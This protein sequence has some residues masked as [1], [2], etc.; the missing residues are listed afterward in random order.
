MGLAQVSIETVAAQPMAAIAART[1]FAGL[2]Q[3]ITG[4]LDKVYAV[5][6][7]GDYGPLGCNTVY[8]APGMPMM[9]LLV[10][11]RLDA[12]FPGPVGEVVAAETPAGEAVH[13]VYFGDY[14]KMKP[15]HDAV[16][17]EAAR[18]GRPI[19]GASWEVYGDWSDNPEKLRTDIYYLLRDP[20][21][22]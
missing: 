6:R 13:A 12:P 8:Y 22:G 20:T 19:T 18:L 21:D 14:G 10:G 5:L 17:A 2:P 7:A 15:A 4:G 3:T 16:H 9:N 11:V 1:D